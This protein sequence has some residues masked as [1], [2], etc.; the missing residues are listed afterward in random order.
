MSAGFSAD[1][2][3]LAPGVEVRAIGDQ[4]MLAA[5][6]ARFAAIEPWSRYHM[7]GEGLGRYLATPEAGKHRFGIFAGSALSGLVIVQPGW[8]RGSYVPF[9][10]ILP[11]AQGQGLGFHVLRWIAA[12]TVAGGARNTWI[13]VSSFN[14]RARAL[15][16]RS[17]Y[18]A[19]AEIPDLVAD[20]HTEI[21]MRKRL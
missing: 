15:Y 19:I 1:H 6:G 7:T 2:D 10:G 14:A 21:L 11:E 8:L 18:I 4:E 17:G 5:L 9:L 3:H 13:A 12:E 20:G 16:E